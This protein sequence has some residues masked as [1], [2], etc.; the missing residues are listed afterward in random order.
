MKRKPS[1][2]FLILAIVFNCFG[3][4]GQ[5]TH[6]H[7]HAQSRESLYVRQEE[8]DKVR[9]YWQMPNRVLHEIGVQS[10]NIIADVGC[11]IGYFSVPLAKKVG[12]SGIVYACDIDPGALAFL[13]EK[14]ERQNIRNLKIIQSKENDPLLPASVMDLVLIVNTIHLMDRPSEYLTKLKSCLKPDGCIAIIQWD[15]EK[16]DSEAPDWSAEDREKYTQQTTLRFIYDA[17]Y[18]VER[19]LHFLPMQNIYICSPGK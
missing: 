1:Y 9:M 18:E 19:I 10:G 2:R 6:E 17:G 3:L 7:E 16:M 13:K 8:Q 14:A 15:A 5:E 12:S 4:Y 11:G